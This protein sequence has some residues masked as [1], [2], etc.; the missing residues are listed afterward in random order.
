[1]RKTWMTGGTVTAQ[2]DRTEFVAI[3][4]ANGLIA[5][6]AAAPYAVCNRNR[7]AKGTSEIS[8]SPSMYLWGG[9]NKTGD[10]VFSH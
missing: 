8:I 6:L 7:E 5:P 10:R 3:R 9:V 1:M 4:D 2:Q